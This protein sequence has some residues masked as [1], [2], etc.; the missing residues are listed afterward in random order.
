MAPGAGIGVSA[1]YMAYP[2]EGG[3]AR[4]ASGPGIITACGHYTTVPG[5]CDSF[6]WKLPGLPAPPAA[7]GKYGS[8]E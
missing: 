2:R 8:P 6:F 1:V 5:D 7:P 3:A 4:E